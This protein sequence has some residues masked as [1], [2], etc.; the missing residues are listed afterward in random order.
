MRAYRWDMPN[1][2]RC[3][4]TADINPLLQNLSH[5][6][7][8]AIW[9]EHLIIS[10]N[11]VF[12]PLQVCFEE[13]LSIVVRSMFC[14]VNQFIFTRRGRRSYS[15]EYIEVPKIFLTPHPIWSNIKKFMWPL[16]DDITS[17]SVVIDRWQH[18]WCHSSRCIICN[19]VIKGA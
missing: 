5:C 11:L 12:Y 2:P 9:R 6:S 18:G 17:S 4:L 15:A 19:D 1:C 3:Q 7:C 13:Q 14:I 8:H 10:F 16:I